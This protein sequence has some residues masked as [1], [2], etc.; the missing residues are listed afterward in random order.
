[1]ARVSASL[2]SICEINGYHLLGARL[3]D[4][5]LYCLLSLKPDHVVSTIARTVKG[6][7]SREFN[8]QMPPGGDRSVWSIG[9]YVGSR[10]KASRLS[11]QKYLDRQGEH[12]GIRQET[13]RELMRWINPDGPQLQASHVTF[14]LS[15]HVVLATHRR[16]EVFDDEIAP[17]HFS[18]M[19]DV[20]DTNGFYIERMSL[21]YDHIHALIKLKP[22]QAIRDCVEELMNGSWRF[23]N[24]RYAG[25]LK[26]SGAYDLWTQSFYVSTVGNATT[27]QVKAFLG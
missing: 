4:D 6:N 3:E 19:V 26:Y 7:I 25:V 1:M 24:D 22:S 15:Y 14:D 16:A 18:C 12:H 21:L 10:G 11:A 9:Y 8:L 20:A 13:V 23:M 17:G 2:E 27:A 5:K